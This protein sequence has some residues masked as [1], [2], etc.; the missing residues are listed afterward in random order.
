LARRSTRG[1]DSRRGGRIRGVRARAHIA[2]PK[3]RRRRRIFIA[4]AQRLP[5]PRVAGN[6][7]SYYPVDHCTFT[8]SQLSRV[9]LLDSRWHW[10]RPLFAQKK[11]CG[12]CVTRRRHGGLATL[13]TSS[14]CDQVAAVASSVIGRIASSYL[15]VRL[16]PISLIPSARVHFCATRV[17]SLQ[18]LRSIYMCMQWE[19]A[20]Q[21]R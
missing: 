18:Y 16:T 2:R 4:A 5:C 10:Q 15:G 21:G 19:I 14:G 7:I 6:S 9:R 20:R 17:P 13:I 8:K 1:E 12:R 3:S 11:Q